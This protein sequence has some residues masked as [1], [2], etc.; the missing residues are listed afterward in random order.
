[1]VC[2][3]RVGS[4]HYDQNYLESLGCSQKFPALPLY[5]GE[6]LANGHYNRRSYC[7]VLLKAALCDQRGTQFGIPSPQAYLCKS[8]RSEVVPVDLVQVAWF[9]WI[10]C[11]S[12]SSFQCH[13]YRQ[14]QCCAKRIAL[15]P[16]DD[17]KTVQQTY[18]WQY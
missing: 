1:M 16:L 13:G 9:P 18:Q 4:T 3:E 8:L 11:Q 6:T 5:F 17:Q 2:Q 10:T 15:R 12:I 14:R 7:W